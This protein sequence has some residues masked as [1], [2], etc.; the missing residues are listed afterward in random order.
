MIP[1]S[2]HG[3]TRQRN[4]SCC[5]SLQL[6]EE[7]RWKIF[8]LSSLCAH[9]YFQRLRQ[10]R[11]FLILVNQLVYGP[12]HRSCG[13]ANCINRKFGPWTCMCDAKWK[14]AD[15]NLI[16]Q[17]KP[18]TWTMWRC[19]GISICIWTPTL[20]LK[21]V[22]LQ[23]GTESAPFPT[24]EMSLSNSSLVNLVDV[25]KFFPDVINVAQKLENTM[26][27]V[28]G[29]NF[30]AYRKR[31]DLA[32]FFRFT[33]LIRFYAKKNLR[34]SQGSN[35]CLEIPINDMMYKKDLETKIHRALFTEEL[36]NLGWIETA[37]VP[38][39]ILS[40]T[41]HIQSKMHFDD[42]VASTATSD[43][44]DGKL[45]KMLTTGCPETF[46]VIWSTCRAREWEE[47]AQYTQAEGHVNLMSHS[48]E[49]QKAAREP[50]AL[51]STE[52]GNSEKISS[53]K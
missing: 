34:Q 41:S 23:W 52:Q 53:W 3:L 40:E 44:E 6:L 21:N 8:S 19:A 24:C 32:S 18:W 36:D 5:V 10:P 27:P 26:Q 39:A 25:L 50:D 28:F 31:W 46:W 1:H 4:S 22:L 14:A 16:R 30:H 20:R 43:L 13:P 33:L 35:L 17:R 45:Q 38:D 11:T 37:G 7:F 9:C 2:A 42:T 12:Q 49:S 29:L 15:V 47:G 51:F 48:S